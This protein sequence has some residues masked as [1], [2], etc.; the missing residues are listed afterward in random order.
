MAEAAR[1]VILNGAGSAGKGSIA[2]AL[3]K[4]ASAPY[5]HVEMDAFLAMMPAHLWDHPDGF[6]FETLE[7]DGKPSVAIHTGPAGARVMS[8]MRHAIRALVEQG[9]NLIVDD[10]MLNGEMLEYE[11]LLGEFVV[12]RI[13]VHAA[14]EVLEARES[15]RGDRMIGLSRWQHER[16]HRDQ[17]YDLMVDT[18]AASPEDCAR[19][20]KQAF[21]L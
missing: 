1:I 8:G 19:R 20:I 3:Q 17:T 7:E 14:L 11:R 5:L 12:C 15:A 4:I 9:N 16:V 18:G 6:V 21:R 10:V 13:G 2:R